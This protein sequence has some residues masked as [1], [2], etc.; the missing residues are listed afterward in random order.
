LQETEEEKIEKSNQSLELTSKL[1]FFA[2]KLDSDKLQVTFGRR[3][4]SVLRYVDKDSGVK[5][6]ALHNIENNSIYIFTLL[7]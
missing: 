6:L 2:F 3:S 7:L 1:F 4:S 5:S